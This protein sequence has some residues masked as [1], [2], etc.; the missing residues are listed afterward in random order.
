MKVAV[1]GSG[2]A[3]NSVL[4]CAGETCVLV[5]AGF[6]ARSLEE[7][8]ARLD[9]PPGRVRAIVVTHDHRDHTR[10]MGVFARRHGAVLHMTARTREACSDLLNG[11]ERVV[12]YRPGRPF[13]LG[14]LRVH[15][16]LTVHDAADPVG[17]A[18]EDEGPGIRLG[19]ATDLG[20]PTAQ[21]RHALSACDLLVLEANHDEVL[22]HTGPYPVSVKRRIASSHGH[23]SNQ[24]AA[25][26]AIDL[27]HPGLAAVV[28]AHL[29]AECNRPQLAELVVGQALRSAGWKGHL[30]VA[31]QDRPT[32]LLDLERLRRLC[33]PAQLS[34]L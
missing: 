21:I 3:G 1:L 30:E 10:G 13:S 33:G 32:S 31:H 16:F 11:E 24:A 23:L 12:E 4:V 19:I 25:R 6:S 34:L 15:P 14:G 9:V 22:L 7:R 17:V 29:S 26:L 5:D 2:S 8:L 28:L 18:L 20:R 27:L